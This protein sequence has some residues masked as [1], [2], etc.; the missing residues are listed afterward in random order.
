M[1]GT[2]LLSQLVLNS[3]LLQ[4]AISC[5]VA[6]LRPGR[7]WPS[8][9]WRS[10]R[11]RRVA[12]KMDFPAYKL[13]TVP[14]LGRCSFP[15]RCQSVL[16]SRQLGWP[17]TWGPAACRSSCGF[18]V[19]CLF[20]LFD[21]QCLLLYI[22]VD[23]LQEIERIQFRD[24]LR[25]IFWWMPFF[26]CGSRADL[27]CFLTISLWAYY[28]LN[29]YLTWCLGCKS[30]FHVSLSHARFPFAKRKKG[31]LLVLMGLPSDSLN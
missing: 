28:K 2:D 13:R 30:L 15:L 31:V 16:L 7:S 17:L 27:Q 12:F 10:W 4:L 8:F 22:P 5:V 18:F 20:V 6:V 25:F 24:P 29:L 3:Y 21:L 1:K 23:R 9:Q 14:R 26:C 11:S 19:H